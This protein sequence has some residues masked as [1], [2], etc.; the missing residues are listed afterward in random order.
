VP[1]DGGLISVLRGISQHLRGGTTADANTLRTTDLQSL[2]ASLDTIT[3]TRAVVGATTN[4]L[5][6]ALSRLQEIE[7]ST[8]SLLSNTTDADMAKTMIDFSMQQAVYQS[9][10]RAGANI[11]QAS[12][13]DFLR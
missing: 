12:L 9:A 3:Q 2:D 6:T 1:G 5:D 8:T 7:Q 4:R 13:L 11:V 10:L